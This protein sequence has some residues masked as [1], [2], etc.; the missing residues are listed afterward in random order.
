M[1]FPS[2]I[3]NVITAIATGSLDLLETVITTYWPYL[4]GLTVL[5]GLGYKFRNIFHLGR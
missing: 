3:S 5:L 4:I 2:A 1:T